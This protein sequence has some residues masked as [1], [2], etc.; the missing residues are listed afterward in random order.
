MV[1]EEAAAVVMVVTEAAAVVVA[2]AAEAARAE[3]R[4][5]RQNYMC[6][7]M[8]ARAA[9]YGRASSYSLIALRAFAFLA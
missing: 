3:S 8:S 4:R 1:T 6:R 5:P 7:G 2:L 9:A